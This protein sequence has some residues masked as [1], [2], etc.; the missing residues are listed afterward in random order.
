MTSKEALN[1]LLTI[2]E[3]EGEEV[4][5]YDSDVEAIKIARK[6]IKQI[7]RVLEVVE[8]YK[9]RIPPTVYYELVADIMN[10]EDEE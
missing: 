4:P 10:V 5:I 7:D 6:A 3:S 9:L 1:W 2:E 8:R